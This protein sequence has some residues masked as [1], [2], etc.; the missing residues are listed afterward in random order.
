MEK[1]NRQVKNLVKLV[2]EMLDLSR[3]RSGKLNLELRSFN[4]CEL[5]FDVLFRIESQFR[6]AGS[7]D[8][9][10][11]ECTEDAWGEWDP[12][13]MEQVITNLLTNALRYGKSKPVRIRLNADD[14]GIL[15]SVKDE[16]I[17]I[18]AD[19][20]KTIF[21]PFE[22]VTSASKTKGLGLGLYITKQI[23]QQH[24]GKIWAESEPGKGSTFFV[25]IPRFTGQNR[26]GN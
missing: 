13:R 1:M 23:V 8:P 3:V 11:E 18:A 25:Q 7:P 4:F 10:L 6:E 26:E 12:V 9:I 24:G 2:D 5:L 14:S 20:L 15:F 17:G 16:G 21:D 19:A 22:R